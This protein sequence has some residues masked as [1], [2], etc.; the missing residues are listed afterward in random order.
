MVNL[1]SPGVSV[2]VID[3]SFYVGAGQ[4]TVPMI[5]ITTR[6]NKPTPDGSGVAP[7]TLSRNVNKL[8]LISSQRELIQT[9]GVPEFRSVGGAA[10]NGNALNE[11][12][13]LAAHSYLGLANRVYVMRVDVNLSELEPRVNPPE[14][15]PVDLTYWAQLNGLIPGLFVS[16]DGSPWAPQPIKIHEGVITPGVS[17]PSSGFAIGDIVLAVNQLGNFQ[18]FERALNTITNIV[19]WRPFGVDHVGPH[20]VVP[21]FAG[22]GEV[23]HWFKTTTPN[24]GASLPVSAFDASVGRF[25]D[26]GT[27]RFAENGNDFYNRFF[28]GSAANVPAGTLAALYGGNT[29]TQMEYSLHWHNGES[30]VH[31]GGRTFDPATA[32]TANGDLVINGTAVTLGQSVILGVD[33][34]AFPAFTAGTLYEVGDRIV[35]DADVV[36]R[37][38]AVSGGGV[39]GFT[40]ISASGF[41]TG[42]LGTLAQQALDPVGA[43]TG[44]GFTLDWDSS[45]VEY[46]L[47]AI[48]NAVNSTAIS[49]IVASSENG[50]F[51]LISTQGLDMEVEFGNGLTGNLIATGLYSNFILISDAVPAYRASTVQPGR[52]PR[53]GVLWYNPAFEVDILVRNGNS[54]VELASENNQL[55]VQPGE[56]N[57]NTQGPFVDGDVWVSTLGTLVYP[58]IR[59]WR[60]NSMNPADPGTW[61]LVDNSD[62]TTPDGVIFADARPAPGYV[63]FGALPTGQF[64]GGGNNPDLDPDR[65]DP[66]LYPR[67]MLLWNTRFSTRNVK[68]WVDNFVAKGID[69]GEGRWISVS[70]TT[71]DG[72]LLTG[73]AAVRQTVVNQLAST[74]V[75]NDE[76]RAESIFFNLLAAP[77]YPELSDE[78]VALNIDRRETAFILADAPFDLTPDSTSLQ[79]WSQSIPVNSENIAYYYPGAA[80]TTNLDGRE[81]VVPPSHITLRTL[82]FNDLVA[83][84][85]F[86]PAGF[87]RGRINNATQVGFVDSE[88]EFVPVTLNQGQRDVLYI[89]NVNPIVF[90]PNRGLTV[91]GQKTRYPLDSALDRVNVAR[92]VNYIRFQSERI[93]EPFLFEPNDTQTRIAVK[94]RFDSFLDELITL[95]G[96]FDFL[97]V[98]DETNNTPARID[99]NELW[100]DVAIAPARAIEFIYIPIRVRNTGADLTI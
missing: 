56:P 48:V 95:R 67:S 52:G 36:V 33:Q 54:W 37:V 68:R 15:N 90:A 32:I 80:L 69:L 42:A 50:L 66:L 2:S 57:P 16:R 12:G 3:E 59:R 19:D 8:Y 89:N 46:S 87:Q 51:T 38:D 35:L 21:A 25:F 29:Q 58:S 7:G 10:Q 85:W 92:L 49:G 44:T 91:F 64:N 93:A 47:E 55:F 61:V 40:V 81:V 11:Y 17:L 45:N 76:I 14:S 23:R 34:D 78:L 99:R 41:V 77:G 98:C 60:I 73:P 26:A 24:Q 20:T 39:T 97:V 5:F 31:A 86:A 18:F 84:P 30:Q 65:P 62:Q 13:L 1:V 100:I 63:R 79:A 27:V 6:E 4:G 70:G 75:S 72:Q 22:S 88:G 71:L 74:V 96:L 82:A 43:G 53:D 9:F 28:A 83:Y 94:D